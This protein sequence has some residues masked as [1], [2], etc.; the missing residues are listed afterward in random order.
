MDLEQQAI[1]S[2][3][4]NLAPID[5]RK[6]AVLVRGISDGKIY[7]KKKALKSS[8]SVFDR[9]KELQ[10]LGVPKIY[11]VLEDDDELTIIEE[12]IHGETADKFFASFETVSERDVIEFGLSISQILKRLHSLK[13]AIICRDI[14]P[15]N[16]MISQGKWY[17]V[18]FD[19]ARNYV[20]DKV[21]DTCILGTASYAP[22]EQHGFGQTDERT[23]IYSL[24]VTM[25]VL[26]RGC[27]PKDDGANTEF[28]KIIHRATMIDPE[29]RY[30]SVYE[31]EKA[32]NNLLLNDIQHK[33]EN[34]RLKRR[35]TYVAIVGYVILAIAATSICKDNISVMT[36][37]VKI[38]NEISANIGTYLLCLLPYLYNGNYFGIR[39][40]TLSRLKPKSINYWIVRIILTIVITYV[41]AVAAV[42]L[43]PIF[44]SPL[45]S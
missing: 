10:I 3:Y 26:L 15:S 38:V 25:N 43:L 23:D 22:P 44:I 19:I 39:D 2:N 21:Q 14:K 27:F 11:E 31:F 45:I 36:D 33:S 41:I 24:A 8:K 9:L 17:I 12:Y 13:P 37:R 42:T 35:S 18:D 6:R 30:Q 32:L 7:V 5:N 29:F 28:S 4:E 34:P 40:K 16:L 20:P 1:L